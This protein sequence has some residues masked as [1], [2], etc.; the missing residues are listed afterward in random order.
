MEQMM[1][2]LVTTVTI[3]H[4]KMNAGQKR[5]VAKMDAWL[6]EMKAW[7]KEMTAGLEEMEATVD[8]LD[9][10]DTMDF[11]GKSGRNRV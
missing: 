8:V 11:G 3:F 1:E 2:S 10:M 4:E 5:T 9:K 6:E 7:R